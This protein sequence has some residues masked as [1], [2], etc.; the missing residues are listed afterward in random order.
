MM[1]VLRFIG[2][3]ILVVIGV[4]IASAAVAVAAV[5]GLIVHLALFGAPFIM[6]IVV[7]VRDWYI[8]REMRK[9]SKRK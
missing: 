5:V 7:A 2:L 1:P 6:L 4:I 9:A 8:A 3:C